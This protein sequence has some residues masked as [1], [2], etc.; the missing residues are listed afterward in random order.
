M[1]L[2]I[3]ATGRQ[4]TACLAYKTWDNFN[5]QHS[6]RTGHRPS[7]RDCQREIERNYNRDMD[8]HKEAM[9]RYQAKKKKNK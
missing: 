8:K 2:R 5:K 6:S 4:C 3:D 1:R 9:Q 7:C